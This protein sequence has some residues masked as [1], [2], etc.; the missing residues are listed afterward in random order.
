M[1]LP[2]IEEV[3]SLLFSMRLWSTQIPTSDNPLNIRFH[4][5]YAFAHQLHLQAKQDSNLYPGVRSAVSYP[6]N[7]QSMKR[8]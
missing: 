6:L 5:W 7:E 1:S 2:P 8:F 3:D 4:N